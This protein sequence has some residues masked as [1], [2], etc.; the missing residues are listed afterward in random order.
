M[1]VYASTALRYEQTVT[2]QSKALAMR[3][4]NDKDK[5]TVEVQVFLKGHLMM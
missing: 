4:S 3:L 1:V 5:V 2:V